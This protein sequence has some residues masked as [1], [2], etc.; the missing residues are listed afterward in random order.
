MKSSLTRRAFLSRSA[1]VYAGAQVAGVTGLFAADA[2]SKPGVQMYMVAAEFKKDPAG[3]LAQLKAIGYGYVEAFAMA[4]TNMGEFKK[5]VGDAGLGCPS[6]HFAFGFMP[7]EKVL[8]DAAALGVHYV[9]SS[10]LPPQQPNSDDLKNGNPGAIMQMMNHL[11]ADDFKRMAAMANE[12]GES[13]KKRGLELA[14][15]NHNVEFRKLQDGKTG[16]EILLRET[17]PGLVKLEVDAGWVAAGGADPAALIAA[18]AE[19][20][21]LIHFKDFSTVTPPINELGPAAGGHIV[22]LGTGVAPLRAAYEAARKAGTEYFI[23]DHDPPF[24]GKTALEA[25]KVDYAYVAGLMG[26]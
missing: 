19:R 22:D 3:T 2:K 24:H 5:M 26:V 1:A 7:T 13:A 9:V 14:Y 20:V 25:A 11:T 18:N 21:K 4:I 12:I 8:D 17:D 15:H 16:Y 6:G 10:V 23:A